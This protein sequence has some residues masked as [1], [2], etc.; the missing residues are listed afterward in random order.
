MDNNNHQR[1]RKN[2]SRE[3]CEGII[4]RIL[5]SEVLQH[6]S[7]CHF[8]NA[9]DFLGYFESLYP[10]SDALTK[11]IQRAVRAL[12]M[13]KDENG[14]FIV[15]KTTDQFHQETEISRAFSEGG[16][17]IN[18]MENVETVFLSVPPHMRSYLIHLLEESITFSDKYIT[19]METS[20]GLIFYTN[21][22]KQL[23]VL[24]NSLIN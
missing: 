11:Q 4:K 20:N 14:Y 2:P 10:A 3:T 17:T 15:N 13:P 19:I 5:M 1:L 22:K 8:K 12:D 9:S 21:N 6:G 18:P 16:V 24:L 7:N 23:L